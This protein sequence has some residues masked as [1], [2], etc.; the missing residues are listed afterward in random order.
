MLD[1][2]D[3]ST[4]NCTTSP[5]GCPI[6]GYEGPAR[7]GCRRRLASRSVGRRRAPDTGAAPPPCPPLR[8]GVGSMSP[9]GVRRGYDV[10]SH[11]RRD[12]ALRRAVFRHDRRPGGDG[13]AGCGTMW[14]RRKSAHWKPQ[15]SGYAARIGLKADAGPPCDRAARRPA[16]TVPKPGAGLPARVGILRINAGKCRC[17]WKHG[18]YRLCRVRLFHSSRCCWRSSWASWTSSFRPRR[19]NVSASE[20]A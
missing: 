3:A 10:R 7:Y 8:R 12:S 1:R 2:C 18:V 15:P 4:A 5:P 9:H 19:N 6:N 14:D 13:V 11:C 20:P 17:P 16:G